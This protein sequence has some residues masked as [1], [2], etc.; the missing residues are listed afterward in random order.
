MQAWRE[1]KMIHYAVVT[2]SGMVRPINEDNFY[3]NGAVKNTTRANVG[4]RNKTAGPQALFAVCDGLGG[5]GCGEQAAY[6]AASGLKE[7]QDS[8]M[9]RY[10]G[11]IA[12]TNQIICREQKVM[13]VHM[14]CTIAALAVSDG[15]ILALNIGDSRIYRLHEGELTI[16][17]KDHNE[18]ETLV[19]FGLAAPEEYY[20]SPARNRLTR[21]LGMPEEEGVLTPHVAEEIGCEPGDLYLLCSDG[22]CGTVLPEEIRTLLQQKGSLLSKCKKMV[23][24]AVEHGSDDNVTVM[25]IELE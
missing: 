17:S 10:A 21:V 8:F 22:F 11:Y 13:G 14:G 25:L 19:R 5:E 2:T 18:F 16:L 20:S 4:M 23:K 15:K 3:L 1:N 6:I 24:R 7:Y 9:E 12:R